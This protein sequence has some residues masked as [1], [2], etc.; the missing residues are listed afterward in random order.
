MGA[1][2]LD[3]DLLRRLFNYRPDSPVAQGVAIDLPALRDRT[4][5][6]AVFD[7][8]RGHPGVDS[9]LDPDWS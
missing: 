1:E 8:G 7:A 2:V 5:Q 9:L 4:Q 6:P 3:P